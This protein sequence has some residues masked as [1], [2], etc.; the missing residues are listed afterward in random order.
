MFGPWVERPGGVKRQVF[1]Q[2]TLDDASRLIPHGQFYPNQGL[3]AFLNCLRQAVAARGLPTRLYMDNAKIYRSPGVPSGPGA[4]RC[5]HRYS[6][7]AYSAASGWSTHRSSFFGFKK[8]PFSDSPDAK[9]LF[10]SAAWQQV[11]ARLEFLAQHHGVGLLTGEVGAGKSTAARVFTAALEQL[12]LLL[13]LD[14][15]SSR[16]LTLLLIGRPL[17][18]R[19]LSL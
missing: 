12:P 8:T 4:H 3:D 18:R 10:S 7:R 1:L 5:L 19:T 17:L 16:Y 13:N 9:Q 6:H 11:N 15:D 2:A 14:M